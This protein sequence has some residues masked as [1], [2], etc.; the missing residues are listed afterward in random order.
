MNYYARTCRTGVPDG[1]GFRDCGKPATES[2]QMGLKLCHYCAE[3]AAAARRWAEGQGQEKI[4][5]TQRKMGVA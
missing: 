2:V 5:D 4:A 3:H 1:E